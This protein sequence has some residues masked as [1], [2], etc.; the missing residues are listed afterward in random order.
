MT[1]MVKEYKEAYQKLKDFKIEIEHLQHLLEQARVRLA[2][3][4]EYWF[5]NV[6]NALNG[7]DVP[8]VQ[9]ARTDSDFANMG[10]NS[11]MELNASVSEMQGVDDKPAPRMND[12][13]GIPRSKLFTQRSNSN[14]G[15]ATPI[16]KIERGLS[17]SSRAATPIDRIQGSRYADEKEAG[18]GIPRT[19][20][21]DIEAFYRAR[22][23]ILNRQQ[24]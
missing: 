14:S 2:R 5:D 11:G 7:P 6:Y 23:E 21:H 22:N 3:D 1:I 15:S 16:E 10:F 9:V 24:L 12:D 13:F 18:S 4:F 19:T 17:S 8:G 20:R